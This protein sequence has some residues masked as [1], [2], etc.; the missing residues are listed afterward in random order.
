MRR[1]HLIALAVLAVVLLVFPAIAPTE[2]ALRVGNLILIYGI[3]TLGLNYTVGWTGQIS[4]AHA[5]FWGIGAYTT[6]ILTAKFA[7]C[8]AWV[9]MLAAVT[10]AGTLGICLGLPTL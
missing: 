3:L 2:Y 9:A 4:L 10:I 5:G 6:A 1:F 8:G 7:V